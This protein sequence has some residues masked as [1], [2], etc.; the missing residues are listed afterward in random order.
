MKTLAAVLCAALFCLGLSAQDHSRPA[1]SHS[2]TLVR[3]LGDLQH[4]DSTRNPE[5]QKFFDKGLRFTILSI[6]MKRRVHS[7][8]PE[9]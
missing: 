8:T 7:N 5:A 2:V 3:G 6:T 4:R 1:Q 9:N